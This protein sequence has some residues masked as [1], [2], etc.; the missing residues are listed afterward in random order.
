MSPL[1]QILINIFSLNLMNSLLCL[2][3]FYD[4]QECRHSVN[5]V[6][7]YKKS[8]HSMHVSINFSS[9]NGKVTSGGPLCGLSICN[10]SL[11]L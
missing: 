3:L 11:I 5:V 9:E 10:L 4:L 2:N 8:L 1:V 6:A 7:L